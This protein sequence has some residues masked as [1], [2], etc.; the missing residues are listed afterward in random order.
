MRAVASGNAPFVRA[1]A[2]HTVHAIRRQDHPATP[3]AIVLA[4]ERH[5]AGGDQRAEALLASAHRVSVR[6]VR[7]RVGREVLRSD[8][9]DRNATPV[10]DELQNGKVALRERERVLWISWHLPVV[11]RTPLSLAMRS[12]TPA[13]AQAQATHRPPPGLSASSPSPRQAGDGDG[14]NLSDTHA[15]IAARAGAVLSASIVSSA[16]PTDLRRAAPV[17]FGE[18]DARKL[19]L[20]DA[21]ELARDREPRHARTNSAFEVPADGNRY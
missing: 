12:I 9:L 16:L 20:V 2:Q 1:R 21:K 13:G 5:E 6:L 8:V 14:D 10:R 7:E 18:R 11:M 15:A 19:R 17:E 4:N 3:A